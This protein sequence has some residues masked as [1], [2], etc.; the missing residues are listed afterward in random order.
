VVVAVVS[1]TVLSANTDHLRPCLEALARQ[2]DAPPFEVVVP[3][4]P[5]LAGIAELRRDFPQVR[6][7]QIDD[8]R[9]YTGRIG[10]REHHNE[11]R[12][13]GVS[14]ARGAIVGLIEDH[15]VAGPR[16]CAGIVAAHAAPASAIGGAIENGVPR[17]LNH[18]VYF[19]DFGQYESP[20]E[21]VETPVM[22]D[23]NVSYKR[24]A[25]EAIRPVWREV[26]HEGAI[27]H[28]LQIRGER[29]I[30][31]PD[32]PVY[33]NR[34]NLNLRTA[35][36]ERWVWGA[37]FGAGRGLSGISRL[38]WSGLSIA[39]PG[40]ILARLAAKT[41]R[42][43]GQ[44]GTFCRAL[45]L[46][47]LLATAWCLGEM[48]AYLR[49]SRIDNGPR[50]EREPDRRLPE[51]PRVSVVVVR[52]GD[53]SDASGLA[54]TLNA[55]GKQTIAPLETI[56]PCTTM[57][58]VAGL[59]ER[60]PGV[61]FLA[62]APV[63][64]ARSGERLDELRAIGVAAARGDVVAVTEEWVTPD[65]DWIDRLLKAHKANYAAIGGAIENGV[66]RLLN[67]ATYFADLGRYQNP[68]PGGES[69]FASVVNVSYKRA[70]L[71]NIRNVW[72]RRFG[73][74][75]V[76]AALMAHG[77]KLALAGDVVAT[78]CRGDVRLG[79][80]LRE[81][82]TWGRSYGS[83][84]A[85]L[86]GGVKRLVFIGLSPLIPAVLL[87]RSG[88]VALGRRRLAGQW[89]KSLPVSALLTLAWSAGELTGYLAGE[90]PAARDERV[91][92]S[93]AGQ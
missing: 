47:A 72:S 78:Q 19:C 7:L 35:L 2:V 43:R 37:S 31:A 29:M 33:Q 88:S 80:S 28:V 16:W 53:E 6:F 26:F 81:F 3:H 61:A 75:A 5:N 67:W 41:L 27:N 54:A 85:R 77:E 91:R 74:T 18:A 92:H 1:D 8:L 20:A 59:R 60:H 83:T 79:S 71:E 13:R 76:H 93:Y 84:R 38:I 4:H 46:T 22:S 44:F 11:L 17:L 89:L 24:A 90:A 56:V 55:L 21:P 51:S 30:V 42:K 32:L 62:A 25:L 23:A 57:E 70:A 10:N 48:S 49:G 50:P 66:D 63:A 9:R 39:L 58:G 69:G 52:T 15:G 73:E 40:L 82:F 64:P 68:L 12:A 86:G 14:A 65:R 36:K 45:P 34:L 87:L